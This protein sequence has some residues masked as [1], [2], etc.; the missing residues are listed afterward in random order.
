MKGQGLKGV[1]GY[2][3]KGFDGAQALRVEGSG[4]GAFATSEATVVIRAKS[5][6]ITR[7]R[8]DSCSS[9]MALARKPGNSCRPNHRKP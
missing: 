9:N 2:R 5:Q 6:Y 4:V 1:W 3:V 7:R 8:T